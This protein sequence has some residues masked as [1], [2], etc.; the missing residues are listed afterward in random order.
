MR[1]Y[2]Q[3]AGKRQLWQKWSFM[4]VVVVNVSEKGFFFKDLLI[5]YMYW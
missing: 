1:I 3:V 2:R 4:K 5:H